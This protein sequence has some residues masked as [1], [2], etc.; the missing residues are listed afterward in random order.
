[1]YIVELPR[2]VT[3]Q[4]FRRWQRNHSS[5]LH[6]EVC[7]T[8]EVNH[9]RLWATV[10]S[11]GGRPVDRN[12]KEELAKNAIN[13]ALKT[14]AERAVPAK[15]VGR[16]TQPVM[17]RAIKTTYV[18][19]MKKE[20]ASGA[21]QGAAARAS[22]ATAAKGFARLGLIERVTGPVAGALVSPFV[23]MGQVAYEH[24]LK[25][26]VRTGKDYRDAAVRGAASGAAGAAATVGTAAALTLVFP[27]AGPFIALGAGIFAS[28]YVGK[29]IKEMTQV[30]RCSA[31]GLAPPRSA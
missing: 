21:V 2:N 14:A 5:R 27:V 20:L 18:A 28:G 19:V 16:L 30:Q 7:T 22:M 26:E 11:R 31:T 23:E 12:E 29:R 24:V 3:G 25:G 6:T 10:Q 13:G 9:L 17:R 15:V 1:M 4:E 8:L